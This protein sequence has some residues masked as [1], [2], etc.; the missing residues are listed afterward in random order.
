MP[1]ALE[2][3]PNATELA[4]WCAKLAKVLAIA[5]LVTEAA[6]RL[7]RIATETA[8]V[9]TAMAPAKLRAEDAKEAVGIRLSVCMMRDVMSKNGIISVW[10]NLLKVSSW[11]NL[12]PYTKTS[13]VSGEVRVLLNLT[14]L[15]MS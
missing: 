3:A 11:Q 1:L 12:A 14:R 6:E 8:T 15:M 2:D 4:N 13:I 9:P 5:P 10:K 7:V